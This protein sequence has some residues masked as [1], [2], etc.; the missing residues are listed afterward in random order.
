MKQPIHRYSREHP[1]LMLELLSGSSQSTW[2][3]LMDT[4][5]SS[6][7]ISSLIYEAVQ[8]YYWLAMTQHPL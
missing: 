7:E 2:S 3:C 4:A 6:V 1:P 8:K 5:A